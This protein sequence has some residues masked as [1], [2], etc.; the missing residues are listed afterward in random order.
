MHFVS[1]VGWLVGEVWAPYT[2]CDTVLSDVG[3]GV[4]KVVAVGHGVALVKIFTL[5][6]R[7]VPCFAW[8][9]TCE[10]NKINLIPWKVL[11][12]IIVI[13]VTYL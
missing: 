4:H 7:T 2:V 12:L 5:H 9:E 6:T 3:S 10:N 1:K 13:L 11:L 8:M